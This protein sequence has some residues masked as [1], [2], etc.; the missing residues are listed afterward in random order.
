MKQ[1]NQWT[2]DAKKFLNPIITSCGYVWIIHNLEVSIC[3]IQIDILKSLQLVIDST[4]TFDKVTSFQWWTNHKH[5]HVVRINVSVWPILRLLKL[6]KKQKSSIK[7][8]IRCGDKENY[9]LSKWGVSRA[10]LI[11]FLFTWR[12]CIGFMNLDWP[13]KDSKIQIKKEMKIG[14]N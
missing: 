7:P 2:N 3:H 10:A 9:I 11:F 4:F 6:K 13:S 8:H 14:K 5:N 1:N 12:I